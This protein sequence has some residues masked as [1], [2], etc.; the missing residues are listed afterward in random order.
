MKLKYET[1]LLEKVMVDTSDVITSSPS[2][3]LIPGDE[4]EGGENQDW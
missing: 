3:P 4:I 1:P 2:T